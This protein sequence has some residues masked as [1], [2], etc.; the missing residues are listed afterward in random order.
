MTLFEMNVTGKTTAGNKLIKVKCEGC[1]TTAMIASTK[2]KGIFAPIP[3]D[4]LMCGAG[5]DGALLR[6]CGQCALE[7]RHERQQRAYG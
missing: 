4:W 3:S 2:G 7:G 6:W 1:T 5:A